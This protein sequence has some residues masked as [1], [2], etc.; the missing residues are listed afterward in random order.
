MRTIW[1]NFWLRNRSVGA[2]MANGA[3]QCPKESWAVRSRN[4]RGSDWCAFSKFPAQLSCGVPSCFRDFRS[5][6]ENFTPLVSV[7]CRIFEAVRGDIERFH[8]DL[9]C[10]FDALFL[11]STCSETVRRRAIFSYTR[12]LTHTHTHTHLYI[13]IYIYIYLRHAAGF[14][15]GYCKSTLLGW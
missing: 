9:R 12:A 2:Q 6:F 3:N 14:T 4:G 5:T 10:V 13:Y 11:A 8:G 1:L 15:T 7:L